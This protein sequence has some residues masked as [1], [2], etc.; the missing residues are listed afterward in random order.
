MP[1]AAP[2]RRLP[3]LST[4]TTRTIALQ[5]L[6]RYVP[7]DCD[8]ADAVIAR[9]Q[10]I[11]VADLDAGVLP[12]AR[13]VVEH[14]ESAVRNDYEGIADQLRPLVEHLGPAMTADPL[15]ASRVLP[16]ARNL[17]L[18]DLRE[19]CLRAVRAAIAPTV[20]RKGR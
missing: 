6:G 19:T 17:G 2:S 13:W 18:D 5:V 3:T 20:G 14:Y 8:E 10:E 9:S 1:T 16:L 4:T 7:R 11:L 15:L 12:T